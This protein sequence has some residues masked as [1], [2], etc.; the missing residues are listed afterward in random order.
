[1]YSYN[2][3]HCLRHRRKREREREKKEK[4]GER[5]S[6]ELEWGVFI[7]LPHHLRLH[8]ASCCMSKVKGQNPK[9]LEAGT[10]VCALVDARCQQ[11]PASRCL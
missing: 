8:D 10:Q 3:L 7:A 5:E 1:M 11:L 4:K 2:L 6:D 9:C